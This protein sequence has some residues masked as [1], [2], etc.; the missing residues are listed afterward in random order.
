MTQPV[1]AQKLLKEVKDYMEKNKFPEEAKS[2]FIEKITKFYHTCLYS[3]EEPVGVVAAQS[4]SEPA[5]QMSLDSKEKIIL[6]NKDRIKILP[7]GDFSDKMMETFGFASEDGWD[8]CDLSS[9]EVFVPSIRE[10]EKITWS[11]VLACS[12]HSSPASLLKIKTLSGREITATDSHSFITRKE[13]KIIPISG[14]SLKPGDRIPSLKFLPENCIESIST[15][16]Y[17]GSSW[18]RKPLPSIL[19]LSS[20]TGWIFGAYLSEGNSTPYYVSISNTNE[21]FLAGIR[22]FAN[23]YGNFRG[24]ARGHDLRIN[25]KSLS[26]LLKK[27]CGSGSANKKVPDFAYSPKEPFVSSLLSAY[28]EGDGNIS[29]ERSVIRASSNSKELIDGIALLLSRFGIFA[30]KQS[31]K[32]FTLSIPSKYASLFREKI[33]LVSESKSRKLDLLCQSPPPKQNFID[34]FSG[35]DDL[36][37]SV[38]R[39]LNYPA[40]KVNSFTRRQKIGREAILKYIVIFSELSKQKGIDISHELSIMKQMHASDVVW[41]EIT[42]ISP[43]PPSSTQVYDLTVEGT[44]T[45]TTFEGL[46]THNTMR[47]YHFAGT[48][49]IQVTLGLP[50][51]LEIFDARKEPK[52][53]TMKVHILPEFQPLDKVKKIAENIKEVRV[54][55]IVTSTLIDL[56]EVYV[57]CKLDMEKIKSLE[58]T[59]EKL[60]KTLKIR[61]TATTVEGDSFVI[62]PKKK[63]ISILHRLK[64]N[65]LESHV[66]GI[67]GISQVI[68]SKDESGEWEINTLGSNLKKVFEIEGVDYARSTSNNIFEVFDALGIEAAR[69]SI[70]REATFTMDEQ[71]LVVDVRYILLLADLMTSEGEVK[72]IGRYG[73]SGQKVSPLVRASF[74][75]TKKHLT[76]A[77]V[78]G[79]SD[80]LKGTIENIMLNQVAPIGTGAYILIGRIPES[81]IKKKS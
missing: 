28:F 54:K 51:M 34:L 57:K 22:Q 23:Q 40:R 38:A 8:I 73:I 75:E 69:E 2:K 66:K 1:L 71:G 12:R 59:P 60:A 39:K 64:Y 67:K 80:S 11:R 68:V 7:I 74:E 70:V 29:V 31:G 37:L 26:L 4:L 10:N 3:P 43:V 47:T 61:N 55:D 81:G 79:E 16:E 32:Q 24:F 9:M 72:P 35:F 6:K 25:S 49:G 18:S 62:R 21:S 78:K 41:D 5:T 42:E 20:Q 53:P 46:V 56:S 77:A 19:E 27:T 36:F 14:K 13:N 48:A 17:A 58:L 33:G 63:D 45:F 76:Y 30:H 44:E 50:R 15:S 52:T 65:L